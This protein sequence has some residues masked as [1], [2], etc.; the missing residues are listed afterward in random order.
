MPHNYTIIELDFTDFYENGTAPEGLVFTFSRNC[1]TPTP[2]WKIA[3][4]EEIGSLLIEKYLLSQKENHNCG[5]ITAV[6]DYFSHH[7]PELYTVANTMEVSLAELSL[8]IEEE[9]QSRIFI[10]N[11]SI[12]NAKQGLFVPH[13][14]LES[15]FNSDSFGLIRN[16]AQYTA[17]NPN[18]EL[19]E[20]EQ[21]RHFIEWATK[22]GEQ[23]KELL[24]KALEFHPNQI[25]VEG[26]SPAATLK[27]LGHPEYKNIAQKVVLKCGLKETILTS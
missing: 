13:Q 4:W 23:A 6:R 9:K 19:I 22:Y 17:A 5:L 14:T 24:T 25:F 11:L 8:V 12:T 3:H 18:S 15:F 2:L 16:I 21:T 7:I 1:E 26:A 27:E 10:P 20:E